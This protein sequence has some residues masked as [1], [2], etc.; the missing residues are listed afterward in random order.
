[1]SDQFKPHHQ[2]A[3]GP[4]YVVNGCCTAC[5]VPEATAPDMF[6][7]DA[8][9]HC[10]LKKQ[11]TSE[12]EVEKT[13]RVMRRQELG[14][15]R[16]GGTDA[17]VLLRLAEAGEAELCD[18]PPANI[19]P[20]L[21]NVVTFVVRPESQG[22]AVSLLEFADYL[23]TRTP[24]LTVRTK[25]HWLDRGSLSI[26]WFKDHFHRLMLR[27]VRGQPRRWMITHSGPLGL[28]ESL[29][30]WLSVTSRFTEVRWWTETDW[31]QG[32]ASQERP[33]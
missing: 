2:N 27:S 33:W 31:Q 14:C 10:Y 3:A 7:Y 9:M 20:V 25:T 22:R 15:V 32:G 21:R 4:F 23:R 5:G 29:N 1:M 6:A 28:S 26:S 11:P 24:G 18:H 13:L 8:D 19:T 16:Y 17:H 12:L 30:D